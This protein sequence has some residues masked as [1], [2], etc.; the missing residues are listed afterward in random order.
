MVAPLP[1]VQAM[2]EWQWGAP[3]PGQEDLKRLELLVK[4]LGRYRRE[5]IQYSLAEVLEDFHWDAAERA[6]LPLPLNV[7]GDTLVTQELTH[8]RA[9]LD[10]LIGAATCRALGCSEEAPAHLGW[11]WIHDLEEALRLDAE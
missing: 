10:E 3:A 2:S 4:A 7:V 8:A 9:V 11:C 6:G 1:Q 5:S